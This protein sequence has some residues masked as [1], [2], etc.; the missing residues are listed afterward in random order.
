MLQVKRIRTSS[1]GARPGVELGSGGLPRAGGPSL[2]RPSSI[3]SVGSTAD[4]SASGYSPVR[5]SGVRVEQGAGKYEYEHSL[6][7]V[8]MSRRDSVSQGG[9]S[10]ADGPSPLDTLAVPLPQP[11]I[12]PRPSALQVNSPAHYNTGARD[13][14]V[15]NAFTS[16]PSSALTSPSAILLSGSSTATPSPTSSV[17]SPASANERVSLLSPT[18]QRLAQARSGGITVSI[19]VA[20]GVAREDTDTSGGDDTPPYRKSST[21]STPPLPAVTDALIGAVGP[22]G[23]RNASVSVTL[24]PY[25][26]LPET[27]LVFNPLL[28]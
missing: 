26:C 27:E 12:R 19:G 2:L 4:S 5:A 3:P 23:N 24:L 6:A 15:G 8:D 10:T 13:A 21:P 14:G 25:R 16:S 1:G 9:G 20:R 17:P 28:V 18:S 11:R 7:R 22:D